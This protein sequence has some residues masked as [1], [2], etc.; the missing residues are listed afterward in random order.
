MDYQFKKFEDRNIKS[1]NRITLT[2]SYSIGLP[3]KFYQ[4][5][6]I[7]SFMY[8][9]LYW[10]E[11]NQAIGIHFTSEKEKAGFKIIRGQKY[12]GQI[13]I[14]SFLKSNNI[15]PEV[16]YGRYE[17]E[18]HNLEGAETLFVIKLQEHNK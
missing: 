15:N 3:N 2:K 11:K 6:E 7:K 5:N 17:W 10:D 16:Y 4:D 8:A 18:K 13:V 9:V 14:R 1:E 12:G